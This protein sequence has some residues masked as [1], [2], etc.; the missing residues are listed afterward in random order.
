ML[1]IEAPPSVVIPGDSTG[2]ASRA[3]KKSRPT[4]TPPFKAP[5]FSYTVGGTDT[6]SGGRGKALFN[7]KGEP[8]AGAPRLVCE[9]PFRGQPDG[10]F[11]EETPKKTGP[12]RAW[13]NK[14]IKE[15]SSY[16]RHLRGRLAEGR[17][18]EIQLQNEI[19]N[20]HIEMFEILQEKAFKHGVQ[21]ALDD[22]HA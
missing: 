9:P 17:T 5:S 22:P 19:N 16:I 20:Y 6:P 1:A 14:K 18:N 7:K 21:Y 8:Y 10:I 3:T 2:N 12:T 4:N 15:I 11:G 13:L